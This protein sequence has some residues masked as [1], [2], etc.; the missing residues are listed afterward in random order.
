MMM[1][2]GPGQLR[3]GLP[4]PKERT[5]KKMPQGMKAAGKPVITCTSQPVS[6]RLANGDILTAYSEPARQSEDPM[7]VVDE[8]EK[9]WRRG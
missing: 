4:Q 1:R 8:L 9:Q 7:L 2:N 3:P 5:M 6:R